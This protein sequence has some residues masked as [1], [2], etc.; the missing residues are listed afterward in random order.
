VT[1]RRTA[2]VVVLVAS[3]AVGSALFYSALHAEQ[4]F[5]RLIA[6][7]D[8][9]VV[10][11]QPF[12]AIEA[13]SGAV[14][15]KPDS[16]LAHLKRGAVYQAQGE[17]GAALRDL[18]QSS[19]NDPSA[20]R[21]L[22]LLGDVNVGLGR[23]DRAMDRYE[24]YVAL[25]ERNPR[26]LYKLGLTRYRA[27][28]LSDAIEP[29][30]QATVL[31]PR[32]AEPHYVI[33]LVHREQGQTVLARRALEQAVK[34]GPGLSN[35][36]EALAEVYI[37]ESN[38]GKAIEQLEVLAALE[39]ASP[40]RLVAVGLAQ[41]R[42]GRSEAALLTLGRA[43]AAFP[44]APNGYAALG[45]IWL[46]NALSRGDR[47]ALNKAVESLRRASAKPNVTAETL[48]E[49]GRAWMLSGE[50][51]AAE[52]AFRQAL[53]RL[54]VPPD[55]YLHFAT[56]TQRSGRIQDARDSLV[57]YAALMGDARPLV[58]VATQIADLSIRLGEPA[59]A[60]R[61]LDRA[62]DESGPSSTLLSRLVEAAIKAGDFERARAAVDEGLRAAPGDVR[63]QQ[64]KR[65]LP[66]A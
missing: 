53:S 35:A 57:K 58:S 34:L 51:T 7:G 24:R 13:Y 27:G 49:L 20:P 8:Q 5:D 65:R 6:A 42:A 59:V 31:D 2:L 52:R 33:G 19:E 1:S 9:A 60:V 55:A 11:A 48:T 29:L 61:W 41:S 25:D 10:N 21:P 56:V 62:V 39:P 26:V 50:Y 37:A 15:W 43:I 12:L 18:R 16:M 64:L 66:R 40:D 22:E 54:P 4:E 47:I 45:H 28:R 14:A 3:T 17:L 23:F 44:D 36:R 32:M 63:L 38:A 46:T 30:K